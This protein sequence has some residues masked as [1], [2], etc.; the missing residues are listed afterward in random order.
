MSPTQE[1]ARLAVYGTL[2]PGRP[3]HGRLAHL[4]GRWF[5][6]TVRGRLRNE[7]WGADM[8]FPGLVLDA[9][10][11]QIEVQIFESAG[12]TEEWP[13]LDAFEGPGYERVVVEA[14]TATGAVHA[15]I[16]VLARRP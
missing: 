13:R 1:P 7:G 11:D 12:L 6:G 15:H 9:D 3:N 4:D 5:V 2:A 14:R 8:G 16:Y 10:G